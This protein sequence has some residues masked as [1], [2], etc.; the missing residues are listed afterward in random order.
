MNDSKALWRPH[1]ES[2]GETIQYLKDRRT[3]KVKSL[4]TPWSRLNEA[5]I[6]GL[7]WGNALL[8]ASRP[9]IGKTMWKDQFVKEAFILNPDQNF[10]VLSCEW[11]MASI[12]SNIRELS[13]YL[14]KSYQY[15]CSAGNKHAEG[16]LSDEDVRRCIEYFGKK[17]QKIGDEWDSKIDVIQ[18]A[19][20][21]SDFEG[22][23]EAYAL[24]YPDANILV[25][26]D[27]VRLAEKNNKSEID[28][29]YDF[30]KA[31]IRQKRA[32]R[33]NKMSFI[34]LNHTNRNVD[35]QERCT[36][37]IYGNY[38]VDSDIQGADALQ[39]AVDITIALDCPA[40]RQIRYYGP[41]RFVI[42]DE[43]VLVSHYLKVRNGG[44]G[45]AFL[46]AIYEE[47]KIIEIETPVKVA[48]RTQT[49][50]K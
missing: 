9:G 26:V 32:R 21:P 28:M 16:E 18:D 31:V 36:E 2:F 5:S 13:A 48:T 43:R 29:L 20:S 3:G 6:N 1:H 7:E 33:K 45:M 40:Q 19:L 46:R 34:L 49:Q 14:G 8:L 30:A 23:C 15:M 47:M 11:E 4:L 22:A 39:Q 41:S 12:T 17:V 24:K 10:R 35:K 27:H 44:K 42:D 25:T 37:G 38:I 50:T